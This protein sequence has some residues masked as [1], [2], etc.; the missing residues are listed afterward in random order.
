MVKTDKDV[1]KWAP[2]HPHSEISYSDSYTSLKKTLTCVLWVN[3]LACELYLKKAD[4]KINK[5]GYKEIN[6]QCGFW[7][8]FPNVWF[9]TPKNGKMQ[10]FIMATLT[11]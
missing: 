4:I 2:S 9:F 3:F 1:E 10:K 6:C 5:A 7:K 11:F 8:V